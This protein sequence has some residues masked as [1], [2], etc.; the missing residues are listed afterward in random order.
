MQDPS[1]AFSGKFA[2]FRLSPEAIMAKDTLIR[3]DG[4]D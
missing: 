3:S 2:G 1:R 4:Y